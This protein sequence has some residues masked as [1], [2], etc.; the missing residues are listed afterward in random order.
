[1]D[2]GALVGAKDATVVRGGAVVSGVAAAVTSTGVAVAADGVAVEES[3]VD[4]ASAAHSDEGLKAGH[5]CQRVP[6]R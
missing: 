2:L 4:M 5:T 6:G 3:I 1:M